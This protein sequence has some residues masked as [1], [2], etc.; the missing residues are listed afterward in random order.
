MRLSLS[1][2]AVLSV[3]VACALAG[4][5]GAP[6][7][8]PSPVL[9]PKP[10]ARIVKAPVRIDVRAGREVG[11]LQA[12]LNG[13]AIGED[14]GRV[15]RSLRR[16]TI[17]HSHGL[18]HGRN[19]LRVTARTGRT[20]RR[21]TVR[22]VLGT[23][24][25]LVGAG[26]DTRAAVG[27]AIRLR[28]MARHRSGRSHGRVRWRVV[29]APR[30]SRLRPGRGPRARAAQATGSTAPVL[31][32]ASTTTPTLTPDAQGSYTL[33]MTAGTGPTAV[34]DTVVVDTVHRSAFVPIDTG[35]DG[36]DPAGAVSTGSQ[37]EAA[38]RSGIRVGPTVYRAPFMSRDSAG[39]GV[40]TGTDE[41]GLEFRAAFQVLAL[42]RATLALKVNRT[43]G[44]CLTSSGREKFVCRSSDEG[45]LLRVED[46]AAE[47]SILGVDHLVIA[48]SHPSRDVPGG[49]WLSPGGFD[50]ARVR[51]GLSAVGR[52]DGEY[53]APDAVPGGY[54]LIGV[55]TMG[56]GE[57]Q[58][59]YRR[60]ARARMVGHLSADESLN[61]GFVPGARIPFDTRSA[62]GGAGCAG[63]GTCAS[64]QTVGTTASSDAVEA[65]SSGYLLTVYDPHTLARV[66]QGTFLT[67]SPDTGRAMADTQNMAD[68]IRHWT[69][70]D[71]TFVSSLG[72][73]LVAI[74]SITTG[75]GRTAG[76][77][78]PAANWKVLAD[79]IAE[80]GGT[81]DRFNT[82]ASTAGSG[83]SLLGWRDAEEGQAREATGR[84]ARLRGALVPNER[85]E[86]RPVNVSADG[87]PAERLQQLIARPSDPSGAWPLDDDPGARLALADLGIAANLTSDPRFAYWDKGYTLVAA[88]AINLVRG[89][90]RPDDAVYTAADLE[91]ARTQL[92]TELG[93][94]GNVRNYFKTL[95]EPYT[96][97]V[98]DAFDDS[99]SLS[100]RLQTEL[101][102]ADE[103]AE[104][105]ANW[106]EFVKGVLSFAG[107][108]EG[109][110]AEEAAKFVNLVAEVSIA[111]M[112]M[113][114]F[115]YESRFNGSEQEIEDEPRVKANELAGR[116]K[117]EA[118]QSA[119]AL[120]RMG[121]VVVSDPTK[122]EEVGRR[123]GCIIGSPTG[124]PAGLEEYATDSAIVKRARDL[125]SLT[126]ERT[127]YS[128]LVPRSFPVW[129]TGLTHDPDPSRN[130][131]CTG[132]DSIN[133]PFNDAPKLAW[134]TSLDELD[135]SGNESR[136]RVS[137]MVHRKRET[138][139]WPSATILRRMFDP[140]NVLTPDRGG[141][142][143]SAPDVMRSA[144][145]RYVPTLVTCDWLR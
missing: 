132:A 131:D 13:V 99:D 41:Q 90:V 42:E 51:E 77:T 43:Y 116:L 124:C 98:A 38:R 15:H 49:G 3:A 102:I 16:L 109:F 45:R 63:A 5:P 76:R 145:S 28:G 91:R 57:A 9:T 31:S 141:L 48:A 59:S 54:A 67:G 92:I 97:V 100:T 75:E 10:G 101:K 55:P 23:S 86:F 68:A 17:S 129:D 134:A 53:L 35:V 32:G 61:Y 112:E 33:R 133:S 126:L 121:N 69:V 52:P 142:G 94:V 111:A 58:L 25:P 12:T 144:E 71:G 14:F 110:V 108:F 81:R 115:G 96:Q 26:R 135:P 139:S 22:F 70:D 62:S 4:A 118:R 103:E 72:S 19:V 88:D 117:E 44:W 79:E 84:E 66:A 128:D 104:M 127:L 37:A 140:V 83:Y 40:F 56:R 24:R 93:W 136:H 46:M 7:Q 65:P 36:P 6:A 20:T 105:R 30:G 18:R 138:Y 47:L 50:G 123:G 82:A 2:P 21:A 119:S 8:T 130:L 27:A 85:S 87:P 113:G 64:T 137:I 34:S 106:F 39:Q 1:C 29:S 95:S 125:A 114:S 78:V 143:L 11:D 122:L 80:I 60:D 107:G 73:F 74:T 89:F 120:E